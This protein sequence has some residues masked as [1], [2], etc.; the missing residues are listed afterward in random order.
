MLTS[1]QWSKY[2]LDQNILMIFDE[3]LL[4]VVKDSNFRSIYANN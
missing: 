4:G 2:Q 1:E 3:H